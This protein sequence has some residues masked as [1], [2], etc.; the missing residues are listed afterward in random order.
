[1]PS[2][3][4]A[5]PDDP[6]AIESGPDDPPAGPAEDWW[7]ASPG[8]AIAPRRDQGSPAAAKAPVEGSGPP[9]RPT[10]EAG[11]GA[12]EPTG[13]IQPAEGDAAHPEP[14]A[15]SQDD[16][17]AETVDADAAPGPVAY[18]EPPPEPPYVPPPYAP[19]PSPA[20]ADPEAPTP[21]R[22]RRAAPAPEPEPLAPPEP[23]TPS[24]IQQSHRAGRR[25][26]ALGLLLVAITAGI[27][28]IESGGRSGPDRY[29]FGTVDTSSRS[30]TVQ[31]GGGASEEATAL[32]PGEEVVAGSVVET[33]DGS[34]AVIDLAGG[35]VVRIEGDARV[36]FVDLAAD[37]QTGEMT[38]RAE[39]V[40]QVDGGRVWIHPSESGSLE[41][42]VAGGLV[43]TNG[44]P[45]AVDCN[46][47]C[48]IEAPVGGVTVSTRAGNEASPAPGEML[49]ITADNGFDATLA[50]APSTFSAENL[51]ADRAAGIA[52][53]DVDATAGIRSSAHFGGTFSVTFDVT[54]N[55]RGDAIPPA[56]TYER[57]SDYAV[58]VV[59]DATGCATPPCTV[60]IS[61][62]RGGDGSAD[63]ADGTVGVSFSQDIDCFDQ[64]NTTVVIP[65]IG[66]TSV[67][68]TLTVD[69]VAYE[70]GRWVA[71]SLTG[72]GTV[73]AA[74]TTRCNP[75]DVLG[76]A[77]SA[78]EVTVTGAS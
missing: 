24:R 64:S 59:A 14:D 39:P 76:S 71:T 30:A 33:T 65:G 69:E 9:E 67:A 45:V 31:T 41:V 25:L 36:V 78:I 3:R 57:G 17:G 10:A 77:T 5:E 13:V 2:V 4:D 16:A 66:T 28:V 63:L 7:S 48:A 47:V 61:G 29:V 19:P 60:P 56:L 21:P 58:T 27:L 37:P 40:V 11:E 43:A 70:G 38:G 8:G 46:P 50:D 26:L 42:R 52:V 32:S 55:P 1:M 68:T 12:P 54:G 18:E 49:A 44:A 51:D 23:A 53:P 22:P 62:V 75:S 20:Y 72:D 35:G 15:T 6:R 34:S 74:L 73:T